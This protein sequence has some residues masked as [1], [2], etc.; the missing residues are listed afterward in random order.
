MGSN[1]FED[2]Q[3]LRLIPKCN[4]V[5][6]LECIG[7]WLDSHVTCPVCRANLVEQAGHVLD[8]T[9]VESTSPSRN[10]A[11]ITQL[12]DC[13]QSQPQPEDTSS[14]EYPNR[15]PLFLV[16]TKACYVRSW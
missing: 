12:A 9:N 10:D 7:A 8:M 6:H 13:T 2:E 11:F 16:Y 4:H 14:F 1:E 5:F 15:P 3:T